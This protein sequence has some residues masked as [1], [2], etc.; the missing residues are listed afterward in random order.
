LVLVAPLFEEM[1]FRG[2]FLSAYENRTGWHA[3]WLVAILF[4]AYHFSLDNLVL[5]LIIGLI[6]GWLVYRTCSI[7]AGVLVHVGANLLAGLLILMSTLAGPAGAEAAVQNAA[8]VTLDVLW[9]GV[10]IWTGIGLFLMAPVFFLLR[11]IGKRYPAPEGPR[12]R[13]SFKPLWSYALLMI[14][15]IVYF[16][17]QFFR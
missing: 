17:A 15:A 4:A 3:I 1:L 16:G 6:A 10:A 7:W 9:L 13:L 8:T 14:V 2:V 11:S 5:P 12:T